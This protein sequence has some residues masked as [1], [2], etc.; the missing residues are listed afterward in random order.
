M[1]VAAWMLAILLPAGMAGAQEYLN[2]QYAPGW[3]QAGAQRQYT[4]DN[5]FD[6]KDGAAEGYLSFGFV[7]MASVYLQIR[8]QHPR[9]R[10]LPNERS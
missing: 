4:A 1:K 7:R 6:Y 5:L 9:H 2:C 10:H 8:R 3:E